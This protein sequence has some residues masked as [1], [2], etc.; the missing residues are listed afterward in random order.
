M[1]WLRFDTRQQQYILQPLNPGP[2]K[3]MRFNGAH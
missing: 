3:I 1:S 2:V